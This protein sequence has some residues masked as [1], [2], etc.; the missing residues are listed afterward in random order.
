MIML[1]VMMV[2]MM[3]IAELQEEIEKLKNQLTTG[4]GGMPSAG[5]GILSTYGK[6]PYI[7]LM[8]SSRR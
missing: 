3:R 7:V 4:G 8:T 2:L 5:L 1:M 6:F